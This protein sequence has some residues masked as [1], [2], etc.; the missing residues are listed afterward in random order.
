MTRQPGFFDSEE[1]LQASS[2]AG[3]PLERLAQVVD[4][5]VFRGDLEADVVEATPA[6]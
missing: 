1:R 4:L 3:N 6:A 2:V 5:E